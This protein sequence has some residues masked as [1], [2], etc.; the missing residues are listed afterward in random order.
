MMTQALVPGSPEDGIAA[1][2]LGARSWP[3]WF[4]LDRIVTSV[5]MVLSFVLIMAPLVFLIYGSFRTGSPGDPKPVFTF[6]NWLEAY[7]RPLIP[8]TL[9][10]PLLLSRPVPLVSIPP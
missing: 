7:A 5:A 10:N 2:R 6:A 9:L 3:L 4:N 8:T 1:D